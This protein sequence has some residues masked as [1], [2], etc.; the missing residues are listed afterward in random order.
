MHTFQT[1]PI[2]CDKS[3]DCSKTDSKDLLGN[4]NYCPRS[5]SLDQCQAKGNDY[6][7]CN[8]SE[9]CIAKGD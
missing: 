2:Q 6:F 9:T 1:Y 5:S 8:E 3:V 7:F 4:D